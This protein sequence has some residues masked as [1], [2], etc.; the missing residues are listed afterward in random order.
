MTRLG[1][2]LAVAGLAALLATA[3]QAQSR[4]AEALTGV[5]QAIS[6]DTVLPGGLRNSGGPTSIA[7][8]A[9]AVTRLDVRDDPAVMCQSVGPFRM[10]ARDRVKLEIVPGPGIVMLLFEDLSHGQ[11][12]PVYMNRPHRADAAVSRLGDAVG[13]WD[14]TTLVIETRGFDERALLN[15]DGAQ[16][17][18]MLRL[19]ERLRPVLDGR[20]LEYQVTADDPG[21]LAK[22]YTYTRYL[23]RL[24]GEIEE[25]VCLFD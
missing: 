19:V 7:L 2:P 16:H 6:T 4:P 12:R 13:R 24:R 8:R 23:E 10:M 11:V 1:I 3:A 14:G 17:S 5:Y 15:D 9:G 22:P 20:Y 25:E 21:T 18:G